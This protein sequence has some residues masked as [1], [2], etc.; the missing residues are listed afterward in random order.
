MTLEKLKLQYKLLFLEEDLK[1]LSNTVF[2]EIKDKSNLEELSL[3]N[4][5]TFSAGEMRRLFL[6]RSLLAVLLLCKSLS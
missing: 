4:V 6:L 1:N 5:E 2:G 3:R